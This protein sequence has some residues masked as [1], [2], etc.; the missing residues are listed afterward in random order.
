MSHS[1]RAAPVDGTVWRRF[2]ETWS[3]VLAQQIHQSRRL[4]WRLAVHGPVQ[5]KAVAVGLRDDP[6][7]HQTLQEGSDLGSRGPGQCGA[8][9]G[10]NLLKLHH[11]SVDCSTVGEV[12]L[13]GCFSITEALTW[14]KR[15]FHEGRCLVVTWEGR[16]SLPQLPCSVIQDFTSLTRSKKNMQTHLKWLL[17]WIKCALTG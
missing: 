12:T 3:V 16:I 15:R 14:P 2:T 8:D 6:L 10:Q 5:T 9:S 11:G 1:G 13:R 7:L 4:T 17:I